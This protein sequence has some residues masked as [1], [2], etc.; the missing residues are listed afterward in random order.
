[1]HFAKNI[2]F[3]IGISIFIHDKS[4]VSSVV[5]VKGFQNVAIICEANVLC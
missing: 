5:V 3:Q 1:M 2:V 4:E